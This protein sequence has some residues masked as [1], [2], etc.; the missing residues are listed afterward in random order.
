MEKPAVNPIDV[1]AENYCRNRRR[2]CHFAQGFVH[3]ADAAEEIVSETLTRL[4]ERHDV[5]KDLNLESYFY[6][7]LKF[8][9]LDWLKSQKRQSEIRNEIYDKAYRLRQYDIT[10]LD[11]FDPNQIFS[12][13]IREIII[14]QLKQLPE[15]TCNI[16]LDSRINCLN[17]EEIAKKYAIPKFKVKRD[18]MVALEVLRSA[19]KD[20]LPCSIVFILVLLSSF[21]I[22]T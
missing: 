6:T 5:I 11:A 12:N 3:N 19:L 15:R 8:S 13:E 18:I 16:F 2:Y 21:S 14:R 20:Y 17:H 1:I 4:L 9:C 7:A 22:L 10:S